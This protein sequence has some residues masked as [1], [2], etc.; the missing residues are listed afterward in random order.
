MLLGSIRL[1]CRARQ[2]NPSGSNLVKQCNRHAAGSVKFFTVPSTL[3]SWTAQPSSQQASRQLMSNTRIGE[4]RMSVPCPGPEASLIQLLQRG[5]L[6]FRFS[7]FSSLCT[8]STLGRLCVEDEL[9]PKTCNM[10]GRLDVVEGV[11]Q[12]SRFVD[13]KR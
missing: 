7:S 8:S 12:D 11:L 9:I 5:L 1:T 13:H 3:W 2:V 6:W 10:A 4:Q